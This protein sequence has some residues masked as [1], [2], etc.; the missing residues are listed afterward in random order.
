MSPR[1][2]KGPYRAKP[3]SI[4]GRVKRTATPVEKIEL[5]FGEEKRDKLS[6]ADRI[7]EK[8][9]S[10]LRRKFGLYSTYSKYASIVVGAILVF[11]P[12][13]RELSFSPYYYDNLLLLA[14]ILGV[15]SIAFN[16]RAIFV[17]DTRDTQPTSTIRLY[18][19]GGLALSAVTAALVAANVVLNSLQDV[20]AAPV[21]DSIDIVP[22]ELRVSHLIQFRGHATDEN[23]QTVSWTW[24]FTK[25]PQGCD[26]CFTKSEIGSAMFFQTTVQGKYQVAVSVKDTDGNS[27]KNFKLDFT[28]SN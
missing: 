19:F 28:V 8:A 25:T 26:D 7:F 6:N 4:L 11:I 23:R 5:I 18:C 1:Q 17:L 20:R 2:R 21:I 16:A 27:S 14:L 24:V 15:I 12:S 22:R 13:I 3:K 9:Q 10:S